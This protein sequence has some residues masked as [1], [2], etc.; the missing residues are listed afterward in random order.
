MD[1]K[2]ILIIC[3][4]LLKHKYLAI[5]ILKEI[6]NS[7]VF[8]EKYPKNIYNKYTSNDS[9]IIKNHFDD[10]IENDKKCFEIFVNENRSFLNSKTEFEFLNGKIN[11]TLVRNNIIKFNPSLII[12]NAVSIIDNKLLD[13]YKDRIINV[14]AGL[15]QYFR[16]VGCNVWAIYYEKIEYIGITIHIVND[17]I[18]DGPIIVQAKPQ[19]EISD[20][21]HTI[22]SK[23][24][25][26]SSNL[27]IK[28]INFYK[29]H[30]YL[31]V[32]YI[33]NIK[34]TKYCYKKDFNQEIIIKVNNLIKSGI[35]NNFINQNKFCNIINNLDDKA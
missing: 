15:S 32:K 23:N 35:I 4:N 3:G 1:D 20:N 17:K 26:L 18:D 6:P 24:V 16:G 2:K 34:Y 9:H 25:I 28:V 22:G 30:N 11:T 14:H 21:S 13:I 8:F 31:P 29:K 33:R 7:A 27:I 12:V 5:K 10:V 19:L